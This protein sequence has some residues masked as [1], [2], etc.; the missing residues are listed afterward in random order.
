MKKHKVISLLLSASLIF[1]SLFFSLTAV[2]KAFAEQTEY[3]RVITKDTPFYISPAENNPLFY[4][5][6]TYYVKILGESDGFYHV[7]CCPSSSAPSIDGYVPKDKLYKDNQMVTDAYPNVT[8]TSSTTAVLYLDQSTSTQIQYI[9]PDRTMRYYGSITTDE[10]LLFYVGY[11]GKLGYVKESVVYP[12]TI[13]DHP[14]KKTFLPEENLENLPN[15]NE[16][17]APSNK[18][19]SL[20]VIIIGCLLFSGIIAMFMLLRFRRTPTVNAGYYDENEYE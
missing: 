17:K 19:F 11:N 4:L 5:P 7:E 18:I 16:S 2:N 20:K 10:G 12:F 1:S 14:N 15:I 13:A 8:I 3:F 6:Y 9:F